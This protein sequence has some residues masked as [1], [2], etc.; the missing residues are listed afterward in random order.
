MQ[1][2]KPAIKWIVGNIL[3]WAIC[4]S[5][6]MLAYM[7]ELFII[8]FPAFISAVP[9]LVMQYLVVRKYLSHPTIF[10]VT[11]WIGFTSV[12]T[13]WI[14][15]NIEL[16]HLNIDVLPVLPGLV[17]GAL[18]LIALRRQFARSGLWVLASSFGWIAG[19][20]IAFETDVSRVHG[21]FLAMPLIGSVVGSSISGF[22]L[23]W[24][25]NKQSKIQ[26]RHAHLS[27]FLFWTV[28]NVVGW[29]LAL[30]I[31]MSGELL[32]LAGGYLLFCFLF[33]VVFC[34]GAI[35]ILQYTII[36]KWV[37]IPRKWISMHLL[38]MLFPAFIL[39]LEP[40]IDSV[41]LALLGAIY[42]TCFVITQRVVLKISF[43]TSYRWLSA[44]IV[45]FILSLIIVIYIHYAIAG[46]QEATE[47][48]ESN[49][50]Y[51]FVLGL[52]IGLTVGIIN[53][54]ITAKPLI[55]LFGEKCGNISS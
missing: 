32:I 35:G 52:A 5:A 55:K 45:A 30:F 23:Y 37:S 44:T 3:G 51:Y 17:I 10:V 26:T 41:S 43:R 20:L 2:S 8:L 6:L 13:I 49:P 25:L 53:G 47:W 15:K 39:S 1:E 38:S 34:G 4:A 27:F 50:G 42:V 48:L 29:M 18:Q 22:T 12:A 46:M 21:L 9:L 14:C 28:A 11:S 19:W 33:L 31:L 7:Q 40:R 24:M 16:I 54:V 36:R